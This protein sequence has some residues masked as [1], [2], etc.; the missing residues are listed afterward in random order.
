M[1][2]PDTMRVMSRQ[3]SLVGIFLLPRQ[4]G[5]VNVL[6]GRRPFCR[7]SCIPSLSLF[8]LKAARVLSN[9]K[10]KSYSHLF[11]NHSLAYLLT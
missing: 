8:L 2:M 11:L 4:P 1:L 10:V 3:A 5:S 6:G 9:I 7:F